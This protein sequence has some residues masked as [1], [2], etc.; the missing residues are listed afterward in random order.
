VKIGDI[1][2]DVYPSVQKFPANRT[3]ELTAIPRAGY[4][5]TGW[6]GDSAVETE[7]ISVTMTCTKK[8]Y[9]NFEPAKYRLLTTVSPQSAG[10]IILEPPQ[11]EGGYI[12]GTKVT[13]TARAASGF[14]FEEWK[15]TVTDIS[16]S[17]YIL[18]VGSDKTISAVFIEKSSNIWV[19]VWCA[20]GVIAVGVLLYIFV[21]KKR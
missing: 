20:V 18:V 9:A 2:P 16:V 15:D 14:K 19:W 11:P 1:T 8:F 6:S 4:K 10:E 21:L 3:I 5:F 12:F 7:T 13:I 17:R